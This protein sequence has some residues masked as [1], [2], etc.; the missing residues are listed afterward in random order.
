MINK[1]W[2]IKT[3]YSK[4]KRIK[5]VRRLRENENDLLIRVFI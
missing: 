4:R 5:N 1:C 2:R 3:L